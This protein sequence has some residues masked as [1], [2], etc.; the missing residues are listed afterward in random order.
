MLC[1]IFQD[2]TEPIFQK[3]QII[4]R[5]RDVIQ[6]NLKTVQQIA[7]LLGENAADSEI[8]LNS[9]VRSFSPED[10]DEA[11]R[12]GREVN[13]DE[14]FIE[15][16]SCQRAKHG[17]LI[18]GDVFLTEKVKEEGRIVSVLSDG[19]GSGVKASVL[20]TMTA[21]MALKFAASAMDIRR[22]AEIIMDTL[23]ICSV[24]KISYS[25]FTVV[26]MAMPGETRIIEHGNPPFL[27]IR[28]GG[29]A[30]PEKTEV[31]PERWHDRVISYSSFDIQREDRIVFFSD[32]ITQAGMGEYRTPFGWGLPAVEATF[33]NRS[34]C[35]STF[36]RANCRGRWWLA[37]R[38]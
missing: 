12:R 7:Y 2:I 33:V 31:R 17:Q 24:R 15:V 13:A 20:A 8:I 10:I 22:S 9:I 30:K 29:A 11:R 35:T 36:R 6:K 27:L 16:D 21:T 1:G 18:S 37:R 3:E 25:T 32:G 19:L 38:K 28:P 14:N 5:A 23:P 26:D 34:R 4:G